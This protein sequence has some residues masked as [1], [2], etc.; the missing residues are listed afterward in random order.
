MKKIYLLN[1]E[2]FFEAVTEGNIKKI[3]AFLEAGIDPN[4]QNKTSWTALYEASGN[5]FTSSQTVDKKGS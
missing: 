1:P 3:T 2:E 5:G 4:L